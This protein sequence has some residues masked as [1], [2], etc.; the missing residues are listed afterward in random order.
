MKFQ[1]EIT[2]LQQNDSFLV[3]NRKR[4]GFD[5][6]IH[7]HPEFEINFIKGASGAKR[8]IGDH[9]GLID[10][11]ELVLIGP[12]IN[13]GWVNHENKLNSNLNEITIQ[14]PNDLFSKKILHL[15][16]IKSIKDLLD[17]SN[18]GILFSQDT[19]KELEE[20]FNNL[21]GEKS[22]D[23][24]LSFQKILYELSK[25]KPRT[26]LSN[27]SHN[28]QDLKFNENEKINEL[29]T[30][31]K[32]NYN[33]K[34]KITEAANS[35]NISEISLSRLI[36]KGTGKTF[37]EFTNELRIGYATRGLIETDQTISEIC[38]SCGFTNISNFNRIFL[39]KQGCTPTEFRD[40]F[41]GKKTII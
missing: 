13:H 36:K 1:R 5:F 28:T 25:S 39:A 20:E 34:I 22:F 4:K 40:N 31:L 14:F 35:L 11:Y 41:N 17:Q 23:N 18:Q 33:R 10:E 8:V 32:S 6:P 16:V 24:F 19:A 26:L 2:P 21:S 15:N 9:V 38:Y 29:Y 37:V 30:F 12:N 3:F 7:Y 27:I